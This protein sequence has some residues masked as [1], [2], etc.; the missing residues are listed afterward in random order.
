MVDR[1]RLI[2]KL[3]LSGCNFV[4]G[5]RHSQAVLPDARAKKV[6][7]A[8]ALYLAAD[9][10]DDGGLDALRALQ[11]GR[12]APGAGDDA[13]YQVPHQSWLTLT[14]MPGSKGK[15]H[16]AASLMPKHDDRFD[17]QIMD[18]EF[19]RGKG[20]CLGH[21]A[22]YADD[23]EVAWALIEHDLHRYAAVGAA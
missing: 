17:L 8:E 15:L 23:E 3:D 12:N 6:L 7:A 9:V 5:A 22:R 16:C 13:F 21:V 4:V 10:L 2:Q 14:F 11:V 1:L 19:D 18:R 20:A